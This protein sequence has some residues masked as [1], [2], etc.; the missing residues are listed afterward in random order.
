MRALSMTLCALALA[1]CPI[2][3]GRFACRD[4]SECP[5][6]WVCRDGRCHSSGEGTDTGVEHDAALDAAGL[7]A[8]SL[9]A[10]LDAG[11]GALDAGV[12]AS[13]IDA[14]PSSSACAGASATCE[15]SVA[16]GGYSTCVLR[17]MAL[18]CWGFMGDERLGPGAIAPE[19]CEDMSGRIECRS[20]PSVRTSPVAFTR[21]EGGENGFCGLDASAN[22][23][24][25]GRDVTAD[26]GPFTGIEAVAALSH[27]TELSLR[28]PL[29]FIA[30]PGGVQDAYVL[31][32][33][34]Q[35]MGVFGDGTFPPSTAES[36]RSSATPLPGGPWQSIEAGW[37]HVCAID[38]AGG[39]HCW[40]KNVAGQVRPGS[41]TTRFASP[42][43]VAVGT[44]AT[45]LALADATSC[46]LTSEG[47]VV[48]WGSNDHGEL[49]RVTTTSD[50]DTVVLQGT[51]TALTNVVQIDA[52][53]WT[54]CAR[55][56][57]GEVYCWGSDLD[58]RVGDDETE[59]D[60]CGA[61]P[62]A[63]GARRVAALSSAVDLSCGTTHC[64]ALEADG[65]VRC[66][67]DNGFGQLG[68]GNFV[69]ATEAVAVVGLP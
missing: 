34:S 52:G 43:A 69:D 45:A 65:S 17:G 4:R 23:W 8:A 15:D 62:C 33:D 10:A 14:G 18:H 50:A 13:T 55:T 12:D 68:N 29:A 66:W 60:R 38:S 19:R 57:S 30:M 36:F 16:A 59:I 46:A 32:N 61:D 58:G 51:P 41:A 35:R 20:Q 67:G 5:A 63:I 27:T 11:E 3:E 56:A 44:A 47:T 40:G 31:G 54:V 25:W 42:Q 39:V 48:C 1:G 53:F 64:C 22:G 26:V 49:G 7:D 2:P 6:D 9:D 37:Y 21:I 28:Y 24:C